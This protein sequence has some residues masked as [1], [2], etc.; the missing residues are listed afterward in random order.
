MHERA[1][2][3]TIADGVRTKLERWHHRGTARPRLRQRYRLSVSV[4]LSVGDWRRYDPALGALVLSGMFSR[5]GRGVCITFQ[6]A[7]LEACDVVESDL[8]AAH[9]G[10]GKQSNGHRTTHPGVGMLSVQR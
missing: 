1:L 7:L 3:A 10:M 9:A 5:T 8:D 4:Q 2:I 6:L